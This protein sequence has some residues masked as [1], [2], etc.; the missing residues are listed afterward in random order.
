MFSNAPKICQHCGSHKIQRDLPA[1]GKS[2]PLKALL[3]M[4]VLRVNVLSASGWH[5][6]ICGDCGKFVGKAFSISP[7]STL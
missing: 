7:I 4:A 3:Y 6:Y 1:K 2:V 5:V